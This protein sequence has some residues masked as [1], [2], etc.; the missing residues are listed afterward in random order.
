MAGT[1]RIYRRGDIYYIAYRWDGREYRESARSAERGVAEQLLAKRLRERRGSPP[2]AALTFDALAAWYLDDYIVRRLRTLDTARGAR[3]QPPSGLRRV[4][5]DRDHN[6]SDSGLQL[7]ASVL[8][9]YLAWGSDWGWRMESRQQSLRS[10]EDGIGVDGLLQLLHGGQ[11]NAERCIAAPGWRALPDP[12]QQPRQGSPEDHG[13]PHRAQRDD[14]PSLC[15]LFVHPDETAGHRAPRAGCPPPLADP[16][17]SRSG[18][19]TCSP[20]TR[21]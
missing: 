16:P 12:A 13:S 14:P 20:A 5:G 11:H 17:R 18:D 2:P 10:G 9:P 1:G 21:V 4:A 15:R 6:G 7:S 8:G 19:P 3:G